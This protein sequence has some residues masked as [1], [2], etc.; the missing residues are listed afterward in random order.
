MIDWNIQSR[1]HVC[2]VCGRAFANGQPY[3]TVLLDARTGYER[4]D[5]CEGCWSTQAAAAAAQHGFVSHWQG[6]FE[7]PPPPP[8]L[9]RRE[10]AET[11]LRKLVERNDPHQEAALFILAVMLERKRIL[12]VKDQVT[13]EGKR[14]FL[15]EQARTGDAFSIVDPG[16]NLDQLDE[17]QRAVS[18]LLEHGL[19]EPEAER[20]SNLAVD[21]GAPAEPA[22]GGGTG[23]SPQ[24]VNSSRLSP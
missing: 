20:A 19:P 12:K 8:E 7:I 21:S 4:R 16:L 15:Y 14:V 18:S 3:H 24:P 5:L 22:P 13:R 17:V 2:Q 23:V 9:I 11:L 1:A 6:V 10:T